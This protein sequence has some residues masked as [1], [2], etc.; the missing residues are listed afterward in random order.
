MPLAEYPVNRV[1]S[2]GESIVDYVV[3]V[4]RPDKKRPVWVLCN[5]YPIQN[6]PIAL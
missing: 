6:D 4:S 5:A 3:G 2:S 1:L